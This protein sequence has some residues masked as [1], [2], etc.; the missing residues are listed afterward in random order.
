MSVSRPSTGQDR[1]TH[2]VRAYV[3]AHG[4]WF[5]TFLVGLVVAFAVRDVF[6]M[7]MVFTPL[8]RYGVHLFNQISVVVLVVLLLAPARRHRSVLPQWRRRQVGVR[9]ARH[10]DPGA[11]SR[12]SAGRAPGAGSG[13]RFRESAQ[14][15]DPCREPG[16]LWRAR[17]RQATG[18]AGRRKRARREVMS[19]VLIGALLAAGAR[20]DRTAIKTPLNPYDEGLALVGGMRVLRRRP[21]ARLLGHLS[22]R[23]ILCAGALFGVAGENGW[24]SAS[25]IRWS[26]SCWPGHLPGVGTRAA[27]W[28]WALAPIWLL[29]FCWPPQP[30]NGYAVF[31]RCSVALPR[32]CWG[33]ST[34]T[35]QAAL[36]RWRRPSGGRDGLLRLDLRFCGS[37][38]RRSAGFSPGSCRRR[39]TLPGRSPRRLM[40]CGAGGPA[41]PPARARLLRLSGQRGGFSTM[42]ENLLVPATTFSAVRHPAL[43]PLIP[44]WSIWSGEGSIDVRLDRMLSDICVSIFRCLFT[45]HRRRCWWSLP[46][47]QGAAG[48]A[49]RAPTAW[50][51]RWSSSARACSCRRS[52]ATTRSMLPASLVVVI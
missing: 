25:T 41:R 18:T 8:D 2:P 4:L 38:D 22:A 24:S 7:A 40:L 51:L 33:L 34:W 44:D 52:A 47:V 13:C 27:S 15:A 49:L 48:G 1:S 28:R 3:A 30:S 46:C 26:A 29:R 6:Q 36:A 19:G 14:R 9:F 42:V 39:V 11:D 12:R 35:R 21:A 20:V 31:R 32:C 10:R 45:S 16:H 37:I 43:P 50:R 5:L 17:G 23:P